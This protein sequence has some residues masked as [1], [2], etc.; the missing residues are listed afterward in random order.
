MQATLAT[1]PPKNTTVRPMIQGTLAS[2]AV[3]GGLYTFVSIIGYLKFGAAAP[4]FLL[5]AFNTPKWALAMANGMCCFQMFICGAIYAIPLYEACETPL[6]KRLGPACGWARHE[7]KDDLG[8]KWVRPSLALRLLVRSPFILAFTFIAAA[9]PFFT[10]VMGFIGAVC[11]TPLTFVMPAYLFLK[12]RSGT[13][14]LW[15]R[16]GLWAFLIFF[17]LF[18][19]GAAVGSMRS[20][21]VSAS[22]FDF[23]T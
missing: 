18:G 16:V 23:F 13:L 11:F 19:L 9:L 10:A 20:I 4:G 21:V 15:Q 3:M 22:T 8:Q 17:S 7:R 6:L 1:V 14:A 2:F 5:Q 12:A